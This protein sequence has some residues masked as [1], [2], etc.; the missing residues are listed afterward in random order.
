MNYR[1]KF[2]ARCVK[3][4]LNQTLVKINSDKILEVASNIAVTQEEASWDFY[5]PEDL[6]VSAGCDDG[7]I[8][9][10]CYYFLVMISLQFC[11]WAKDD[12]GTLQHWHYQGNPKLK[13]SAGLAQLMIHQYNH[14]KFPGLHLNADE[15]F[16]HYT[17]LFS[18]VG[19]PAA[20]ERVKILVS[21][22]GFDDF[23]SEIYP[24]FLKDR[25]WSLNTAMLLSNIYESAYLDPFF[26]KVQLFLGT[27]ASNLR[28]RGLDVQSDFTAY[29]DYRLPQVLRQLGVLE[30]DAKLANLI[31]N[32]NLFASGSEQEEIL[33]ASTVLACELLAENA[34]VRTTDVD[35]YL[36]LKTR[37]ESFMQGI[38]PFHLV[39]TTHY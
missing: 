14:G 10:V 37:D 25:V 15:T 20:D 12:S 36:F 27:V 5:L 6:Q 9:K 24:R 11:F 23:K 8:Q 33:R 34:G 16:H 21:L 18:V 2:I 22:A 1:E 30:Y 13:G 26:K 7:L 39:K 32:Q 35:C 19:I 4:T 31:D 28:A 17:A 38:Q 29:A 3:L